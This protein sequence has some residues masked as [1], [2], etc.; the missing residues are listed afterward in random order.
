MSSSH[1]LHNMYMY[2]HKNDKA[3]LQMGSGI[4]QMG[5]CSTIHE[6]LHIKIES[7]FKQL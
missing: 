7:Y 4:T 6:R 5:E 2:E 1:M 3:G